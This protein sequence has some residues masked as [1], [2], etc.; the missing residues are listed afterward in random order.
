MAG[1]WEWE[2]CTRLLLGICSLPKRERLSK[3][4]IYALG[5]KVVLF[6]DILFVKREVLRTDDR[7]IL[8]LWMSHTTIPIGEL[9]IL[10]SH[11]WGSS[12]VSS[13]LVNPNPYI[14]RAA[15]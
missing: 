12:G 11:M 5:Q 1:E 15:G 9:G 6:W 4:Q 14:S 13:S 10:F 2:W 8:R 7:G 3:L